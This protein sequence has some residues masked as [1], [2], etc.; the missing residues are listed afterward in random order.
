VEK[1][2]RLILSAEM[3][4]PGQAVLEFKILDSSPARIIQQTAYFKPKGLLGILYWFALWPFHQYVFSGMIAA[5][6]KRSEMNQ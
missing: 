3:K 5:I 2:K 6:R 4:L 1:D